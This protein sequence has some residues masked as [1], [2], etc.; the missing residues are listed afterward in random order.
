MRKIH[1]QRDDQPEFFDEI[2][3]FDNE[4]ERSEYF[5]IG[6]RAIND[7]QKRRLADLTAAYM[8]NIAKAKKNR[9]QKGRKAARPLFQDIN[10]EYMEKVKNIHTLYAGARSKLRT[11]RE[12]SFLE[13]ELEQLGPVH[14]ETF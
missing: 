3:I 5:Q 13:A 9:S 14:S 12:K 8:S 1:V 2:L 6:D 4:E 11:A 7:E 10:R